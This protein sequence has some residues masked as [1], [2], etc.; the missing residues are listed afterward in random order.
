V[1]PVAV[2]VVDKREKHPETVLVRSDGIWRKIAQ[3]PAFPEVF[4][5]EG[6]EI[7]RHES[8]GISA[9]QRTL[10]SF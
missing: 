4:A 8:A 3:I 5:E 9:I 6:F 2:P 7:D 10:F 1:L